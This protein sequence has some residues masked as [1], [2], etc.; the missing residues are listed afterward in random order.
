MVGE[1]RLDGVPGAPGGHT[2]C[3]QFLTLLCRGQKVAFHPRGWAAGH[4]VT[5]FLDI[6][7]DIFF[8]FIAVKFH[9]V[10]FRPVF[11]ERLGIPLAPS[12]VQG[13]PQPLDTPY[14]PKLTSPGHCSIS[15][16]HSTS[17]HGTPTGHW[18]PE[19]EA[20]VTMQTA[21]QAQSRS[22]S[23]VWYKSA[24]GLGGHSRST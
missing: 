20:W 6:A 15:L 13:L 21:G 14:L 2:L 7:R 22:F 23:P 8:S 4:L 3:G 1:R 18:D 24:K 19:G 17:I 16:I 10:G 11:P 5:A 12:A 9:L